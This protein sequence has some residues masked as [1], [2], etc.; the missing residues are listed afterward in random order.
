VYSTAIIQVNG[1]NFT[2][3]IAQLTPLSNE[4]DTFA[5]FKFYVQR[6]PGDTADAITFNWGVGFNWNGDTPPALPI[7]GKCLYVWVRQIGDRLG[8]PSG[9][10]DVLQTKELDGYFNVP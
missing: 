4:L 10:W 8:V 9:N 3:D 6:D 1:T 2:L 5:E 7:H